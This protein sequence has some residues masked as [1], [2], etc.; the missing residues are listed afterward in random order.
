MPRAGERVAGR[1]GRPRE[2]AQSGCFCGRRKII[3][4]V[5]DPYVFG[6]PGSES[7]SLYH[8][9]K[10]VRKTLIPTVLRLND[11]FLSLK[12]DVNV[13]YL[14]KVKSRKTFL[15]SVFGGV[16]K[17]NGENSRIRIQIRIF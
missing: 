9:A 10:I 5:A 13:P 7:G 17:V 11:D 16:L 15:K 1:T 6:P 2:T 3:S 4:S 14:Q 8:Q 12:N